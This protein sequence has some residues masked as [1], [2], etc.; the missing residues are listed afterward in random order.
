M[1]TKPHWVWSAPGPAGTLAV[2]T[3]TTAPAFPVT[4]GQYGLATLRQLLDAGFSRAAI[5][6]AEGRTWQC[7]R[8]GVYASHLGPLDSDTRLAAAALWAGPSAVLTA[9][10]ALDRHGLRG[11]PTDE[12]VFL[13][14]ATAR[15]RSDGQVRT[16]RTNREIAIAKESGC[17]SMV[18]VERALVDLATRERPPARDLKALT[19]SALQRRLTHADRVRAELDRV[20]RPTTAPVWEALTAFARGAWSVPEDAFGQLLRSDPDLPEAC[21]NVSLRTMGGRLIGTPDVF[22]PCAGV[23]AQVHSKQFHS[24]EDED[25]TDLW[26]LTV[27]KDG[28]FTE[29]DVIVVGVTPRSIAVRPDQTL[30]RVRTVVLRNVGRTYGPVVI[31]GVVHGAAS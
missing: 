3:R 29:H 7:P 18:G 20:R 2:M 15:S 13:V 12:A 30:A 19:M 21:Y 9:G 28:A 5:R 4:E 16:V 26:S 31:S 11:A 25:G 6:H 17:I 8:P 27:E 24:G 22:F 1:S 14:P 23:A 10:V